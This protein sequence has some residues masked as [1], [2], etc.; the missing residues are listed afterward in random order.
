MRRALPE[1]WTVQESAVREQGAEILRRAFFKEGV[2]QIVI[3]YFSGS[4][5]QGR[6]TVLHRALGYQLILDSYEL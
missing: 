4:P 6:V 3:D 1:D 5:W 2:A